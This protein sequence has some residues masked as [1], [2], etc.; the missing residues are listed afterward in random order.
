[1]HA[2]EVGAR[3]REA[4]RGPL[5]EIVARQPARL[6]GDVGHRRGSRDGAHHASEIGARPGPRE[7]APDRAGNRLPSGTSTYAASAVA[8]STA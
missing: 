6:P 2:D 4:E 7:R 1:M 3:E 8:E 5:R